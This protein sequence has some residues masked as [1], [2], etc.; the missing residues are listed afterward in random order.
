MSSTYKKIICSTIGIFVIAF[1]IGEF[2]F[3]LHNNYY[4]D[5]PVYIARLVISI[6]IT[7]SGIICS[8][9][10]AEN[11]DTRP[12]VLF[13]LAY[14]PALFNFFY[15]DSP[16]AEY[17][18]PFFVYLF[19][20]IF[21]IAATVCDYIFIARTFYHNKSA[22]FA[23]DIRSKILCYDPIAF[24]ILKYILIAVI[25]SWKITD[26]PMKYLTHI[27][28]LL[29]CIATL[30][31]IFYIFF[32]SSKLA[33]VLLRHLILGIFLSFLPGT[34]LT[35]KNAVL[36]IDAFNNS[37]LIYMVLGSGF[38]P[39]TILT[40]LFQFRNEKTNWALR[41]ILVFFVFSTVMVLLIQIYFTTLSTEQFK[42]ACSIFA[43][44]SP[45]TYYLISTPI[46]K[47]L[48]LETKYIRRKIQS[49]TASIENVTDIKQVFIIFSKNLRTSIDCKYIFFRLIDSKE[50]T[51]IPYSDI[52]DKIM[53]EQIA[54]FENTKTKKNQLTLEDNSLVFTI[55]TN[56]GKTIN[57]F[58][59]GKSN[60]DEF[61]PSEITFMKRYVDI[62]EK[63]LI[64]YYSQNLSNELKD[65]QKHSN[66][67]DKEILLASN[68]Q[69]SF[70]PK[71]VQEL[72]GWDIQFFCEAMAGVSGDLYDF[73][74]TNDNLD[75]VGVFDVSGHG[76]AS[77]L[78]TMLVR[79]IIHQEFYKNSELPLDK[80]M[81]II[82]QRF[83]QEK[84]QIENFMTGILLRINGN[85]VEFVN[86]G[87]PY[88]LIYK[89][90]EDKLFFMDKDIMPIGTIIGL[91]D[92]EPQFH[93]TSMDFN[94]GDEII[95]F[96]DG[97]NEAINI[98]REQ[99]SL[100]RLYSIIQNNL[101][102][103]AEKQME[104]VVNSVKNFVGTAPANDDITVVILKKL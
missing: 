34:M 7:L 99:F 100:N 17:S 98:Q 54:K 23:K 24:L 79:N 49:F 73:F 20:D 64:A 103:S 10:Y 57:L 8:F 4:E 59:G 11:R 75:G 90:S 72:Q 86:G 28:F 39:L 82:D 42:N 18:S 12:V 78:V 56:L 85:S 3:C 36:H 38:L 41:Q 91:N 22:S 29:M 67:L 2:L 62:L 32:S 30:L 21:G 52:D 81:D 101:N 77:G 45:I 74:I 5:L 97:I 53:D 13:L 104:A 35:I 93:S 68:V 46:D 14:G 60:K 44:V 6:S 92:F 102:L 96:T 61:V 40:S 70:Y 43:I 58:I 19:C 87:H 55:N 25:P 94:P 95:L 50:G 37:D 1:L 88:P 80:V 69:K 16:T 48:T 65:I 31:L 15:L 83:K 47:F 71:N 51:S 26:N 76:I 9:T 27:F 66:L 89:K 63:R 84:N 33:T